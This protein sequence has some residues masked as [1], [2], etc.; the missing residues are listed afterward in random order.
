MTDSLYVTG[1]ILLSQQNTIVPW[2]H[3]SLKAW[4]KRW[5]EQKT[6]VIDSQTQS[7]S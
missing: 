3:E 2:T 7:I 5:L 1:G 6:P 4:Q